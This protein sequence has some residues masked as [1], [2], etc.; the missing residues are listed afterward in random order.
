[1]SRVDAQAR[2]YGDAAFTNLEDLPSNAADTLK[3]S[4]KL[5][6]RHSENASKAAG[7]RRLEGSKVRA[8]IKC[9]E[10]SKRQCVYA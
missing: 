6:A 3:A 9:Y 7:M 8:F 1:M 4:D 10:C 5:R 2:K